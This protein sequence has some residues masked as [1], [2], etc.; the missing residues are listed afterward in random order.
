[1]LVLERDYTP[2][3]G[4]RVRLLHLH[5][6]AIDAAVLGSTAASR[7][8]TGELLLDLQPSTHNLDNME[9]LAVAPSPTGEDAVVSPIRWIRP[10]GHQ[11]KRSLLA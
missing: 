2:G 6:L 10:L 3:V 9:G 8:V 11:K 5:P 4:N 1:M 7:T